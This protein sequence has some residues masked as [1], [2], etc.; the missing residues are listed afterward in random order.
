MRS[1]AASDMAKSS[2][3]NRVLSTMACLEKGVFMRIDYTKDDTVN[4]GIDEWISLEM[5]SR[6]SI[7]KRKIT[8]LLERLQPEDIVIVS[9]LSRLGRSIKEVLSTV[10]TLVEDK[11]SRLML[12]LITQKT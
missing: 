10:E 12:T 8:Q 11:R 5:S 6:K 1:A 2:R 9:E 7:R 4:V 3:E